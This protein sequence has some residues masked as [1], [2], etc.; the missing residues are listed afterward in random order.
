MQREDVE[1]YFATRSGPAA[2]TSDRT[3]A[4]LDTPRLDVGEVREELEKVKDKF[5]EQRRLL[6]DQHRK[7][8]DKWMMQLLLVAMVHLFFVVVN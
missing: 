4:R 2:K 5:E 3:L 6:M 1:S 7:Q 8:F